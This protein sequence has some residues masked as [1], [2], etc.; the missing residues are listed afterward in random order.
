ML[1]E[2][3]LLR[4][5]RALPEADRRWVS[6]VAKKLPIGPCRGGD[7]NSGCAVASAVTVGGAVEAPWRLGRR[8]CG[9]GRPSSRQRR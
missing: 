6:D 4:R 5:R 7:G 3:Y 9:T 1:D 8:R 2:R